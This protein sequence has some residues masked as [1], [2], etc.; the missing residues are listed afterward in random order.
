MRVWLSVTVFG[1][2]ALVTAAVV[3]T[4]RLVTR[5][6]RDPQPE[7]LANRSRSGPRSP[8]KLTD[9]A[10]PYWLRNSFSNLVLDLPGDDVG[11]GAGAQVRQSESSGAAGQR[12]R[13]QPVGD[14]GFMTIT[15]VRSDRVLAIRDGSTKDGAALVQAEPGMFDH[16]QEWALEDAGNGQVWIVNR[17]SGKV[18]D[19]PGDDAGRKIGTGIQQWQR[20]AK[21]KDQRWLL[22]RQ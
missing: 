20:Q 16:S 15:N 9:T 5:L 22:V 8:V 17:H 18:L 10:A 7:Q 2:A 13:F 12:W 4:P 1:A 21:A 14:G 6:T 11:G 3:A 19:V